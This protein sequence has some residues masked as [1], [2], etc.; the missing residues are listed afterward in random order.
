MCQ[1]VGETTALTLFDSE[2]ALLEMSGEHTG[3]EVSSRR[4]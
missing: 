3:L 1:A 2:N 4:R